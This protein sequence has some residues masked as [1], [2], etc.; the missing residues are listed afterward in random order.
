MEAVREMSAVLAVPEPTLMSGL[1]RSYVNSKFNSWGFWQERHLE[2]NGYPRIEHVTAY[3][4]TP[5]GGPKT[6]K[7][8]AQD[9]P[10]PISL[11]H[12]R[13]HFALSGAQRR[14]VYLQYVIRLK[15]DGSIWTF[16]ERCRTAGI[17][18][19]VFKRDLQRAKYAFLGLPA[20][21]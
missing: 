20:P 10:E 6:H 5:G 21:Y 2:V 15:E 9:M 8:L 7:I 12:I 1:E 3:I 19:A 16:D 18:E 14:A 13:I 4:E 17:S 11:T